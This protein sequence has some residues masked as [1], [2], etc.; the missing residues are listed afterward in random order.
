MSRD[1]FYGAPVKLMYTGQKH[2]HARMNINVDR[3]EVQW[4]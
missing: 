1:Y 4:R 3:G 2:M